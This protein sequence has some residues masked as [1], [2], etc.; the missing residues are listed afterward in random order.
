[1][2]LIEMVVAL[3]VIG[4]LLL[5]LAG[6]FYTAQSTD[7]QNRSY[8]DAI[9]LAN[10]ALAKYDAVAWTNLGFYEDQ[11]SP[12]TCGSTIPSYT[13]PGGT[14]QS[15]VDLG[16]APVA[17]NAADVA[18]V[19]TS[20]KVGNVQYTLTTYVVWATGSGTCTGFSSCAKAE[21]QVYA[22][23]TWNIGGL[24]NSATQNILVYPGGLGAYNGGNQEAPLGSSAP[25]NVANLVVV[26][27]SVTYSSVELQWTDPGSPEPGW[28]EIVA[29]QSLVNLPTPGTSG[30]DDSWDPLGAQVVGSVAAPA[31]T[32]P[33]LVSGLSANTTYIFV[34]VAFSPD[35]TKWAVSASATN[36]A[37][38]TP[39][40]PPGACQLTSLTVDQTG[41]TSIDT[42]TVKRGG[43]S[44]HLMNNV[45]ITV[46]FTG[47]CSGTNQVLVSASGQAALGPYTLTYTSSPAQFSYNP[48]N[49]LCPSTS[50][51]TGNYVFSV[52]L[53]GAA[54]NPGANVPFTSVNGSAKC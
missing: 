37:I 6:V 34:V 27:G 42:V 26:G 11:F 47:S 32:S 44:G 18:P 5:P 21:K 16:C 20:L 12:Y 4:I 40:S 24:P 45:S 39:S 51:A 3:G 41:Q 48:P 8:G 28:Y 43:T 10:S 53:D 17:P 23:V 54:Q 52:T 19:D 35:G 14:T 9:A 33:V 36:P 7:A 50:F 29:A 38:T 15:G 25:P 2:T 31:G 30:T 1:M 22:R 49:G 46:G 13:P